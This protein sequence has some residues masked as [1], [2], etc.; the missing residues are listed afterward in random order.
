MSHQQPQRIISGS[1]PTCGPSRVGVL[2]KGSSHFNG[3]SPPWLC[4]TWKGLCCNCHAYL[5]TYFEDEQE[6]KKLEWT[7]IDDEAIDFLFGQS[8]PERTDTQTH[9]PWDSELDD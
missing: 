3:L 8:A 1:C 7:R 2:L 6:A 9:P 4:T 5:E